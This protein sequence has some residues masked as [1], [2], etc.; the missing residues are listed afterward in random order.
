MFIV[1]GTLLGAPNAIAAPSTEA[2]DA[3][4]DRYSTF[5]GAGS[6]LGAPVGEAVDVPGGAE[7][8]YQGG[9][10]YYSKD[11]GAHVMYGVI[12]ERYR[13]LGGPGSDHPV[14]PDE[15]VE[16]E[17][18]AERARAKKADAERDQRI[19][20]LEKEM[21]ELRAAMAG[22]RQ[23]LNAAVSTVRD[24]STTMGGKQASS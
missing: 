23:A 10:I 22:D 17:V 12:L 15:G 16:R 5:G 7:Q 19:A 24:L 11:T 18:A 8:G 9:A 2:V 20:R 13:A 21:V 3:I 4:N 1:A 6:L 14:A